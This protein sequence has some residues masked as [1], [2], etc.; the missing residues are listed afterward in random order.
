[1]LSWE[2]LINSNTSTLHPACCINYCHQQLVSYVKYLVYCGLEVILESY[3]CTYLSIKA[4]KIFCCH[5]IT[6]HASSKHK[7]FRALFLCMTT[8][9][10]WHSHLPWNN[11]NLLCISLYCNKVLQMPEMLKQ[12]LPLHLIW[13]CIYDIKFAS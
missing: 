13:M 5:V 6:C 7:A 11:F 12:A 9:L 1:M 2:H 10:C 3:V 8:R 4:I